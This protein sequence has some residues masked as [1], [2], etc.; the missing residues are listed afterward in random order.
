MK[1]ICIVLFAVVVSQ[2]ALHA[3]VVRNAAE[4]LRNRQQ[5]NKTQNLL[6]RNGREL[7]NFKE[8]RARFAEAVEIRDLESVLA[9]RTDLLEA[10]GREIEQTETRIKQTG[11]ELNQSQREKH[12]EGK[13]VRDSRS[14]NKGE[15][16]EMIDAPADLRDAKADRKDEKKDVRDDRKD[17]NT[18]E[19]RLSDQQDIFREFAAFTMTEKTAAKSL[20]QQ[21]RLVDAFQA[22]L[23]D[24][25]LSLQSELGEDREEKEEDKQERL[26]DKSE[27][28]EN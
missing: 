18:A 11:K 16:E 9:I 6:D 21:V 12:S 1:R 10:M 25:L 23:E 22:T 2:A 28:K 13:E 5:I 17:H 15:P 27:R 24:D 8:L 4:E 14:D 3:Q 19:S 20:Q 7:E 26:E